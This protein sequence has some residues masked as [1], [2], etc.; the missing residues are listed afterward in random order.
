MKITSLLIL[1][2]GLTN[3]AT[4]QFTEEKPLA[5]YP[6]IHFN[7]LIDDTDN[8]G[9]YDNLTSSVFKGPRI[10]T[11]NGDNS[12]AFLVSLTEYGINY[13]AKLKSN[14]IGS[15]GININYRHVGKVEDWVGTNKAPGSVLGKADSTDIVN[16]SVSKEL[17]GMDWALSV[18]NLTDEYYQKPYGYNQIGR[19]FKLSLRSK[20]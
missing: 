1:S 10:I 18:K 2:L 16:A 19:K 14:Y 20:Y 5:W 8:G 12:F 15:Y 6:E 17:F 9:H 11:N 7:L 4:C 13:N 3:V